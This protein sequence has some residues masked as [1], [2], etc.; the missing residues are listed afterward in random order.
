MATLGSFRSQAMPMGIEYFYLFADKSTP[1]Y[2][3]KHATQYQQS[4]VEPGSRSNVRVL[5][6]VPGQLESN[7]KAYP[8]KTT[9]STNN[10]KPTGLLQKYGEAAKPLKFGLFTGSYQKNKSGGVLR[11]NIGAISGN[12]TA[13]L[14][15]ID[16]DGIFINQ[17]AS[18]AGIINT[19]KEWDLN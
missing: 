2:T 8:N 16:T 18:D 3:L 1:G 9:P 17:G 12:A 19:L 10:Y 11:D 15:E 5:A 7:C 14:N 4:I 6:C 13:A